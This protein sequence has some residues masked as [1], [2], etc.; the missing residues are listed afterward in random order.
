MNVF[1]GSDPQLSRMM[2]LEGKTL[3]LA[4]S[5]VLAALS[6]APKRSFVPYPVPDWDVVERMGLEAPRELPEAERTVFERGWESLQAGRLETASSDIEPLARKYER[7]PEIAT[8]AGFL[9]L[10]LG[11]PQD[12]ERKFQAALRTDPDLGPAQSGYFLVA[13]QSGNE[14]RAFERLLRLEEDFPEHDL[15]D[16][17]GA[18]LRVN[19]AERR[20]ASAR[21]QMRER[22]YDEAA[23]S[24]LRAL[25]VA[26]QAGAL[27]LE[28]A[29]AEI[30]AGYPDRA[31]VHARRATELEPG[32]ADAHRTLG[33]ACLRNDDVSGAARALAAASALRPE[34]E[35]LRARF[36]EVQRSA[37]ETSVPEEYLTI[38]ESERLTREQLAALLCVDLRESFDAFGN[39]ASVIATDVD[40]SWAS[41]YILRAVSAGVLDVFP[42]HTFQ[43][44]AFVSRLDLASALYRALEKLAP[45]AREAARLSAGAEFKDLARQNPGYDAASTAIALELLEPADDGAFEP[46]RIVSGREAASAI[47]SLRTRLGR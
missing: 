37:R 7:S 22:K 10:R 47:A 11:K 28:A 27:Y 25:E 15:V 2:R 43:P 33:E 35:A 30:E 26:P 46:R 3:V 21:E 42:N 17:H 32:N 41:S 14:E 9:D 4:G 18:A 29:E 31:V 39:E 34:D 1:A 5:A 23:A 40:E 16:R 24:Y 19:V 6:C 12:A 45:E 13:L 44:S 38:R 36:E 8:A 20:L